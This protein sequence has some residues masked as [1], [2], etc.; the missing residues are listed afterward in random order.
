MLELERWGGV[1]RG[2]RAGERIQRRNGRL[3]NMIVKLKD[4]CD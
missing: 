3:L 4:E 1:R 2:G